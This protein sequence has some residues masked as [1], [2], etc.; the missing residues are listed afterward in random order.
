[1][2]KLT[3]VLLVMLLFGASSPAFAAEYRLNIYTEGNGSVA[4]VPDKTRYAENEVVEL[5]GIAGTDWHFGYWFLGYDAGGNPILSEGNPTTVIMDSNKSIGAYF[6]QNYTL[7]I[8]TTGNG[9]VTREPEYQYY[10]P[11]T[12]VTLHATP[13]L[14]HH[15]GGWYM[16]WDPVTGRPIIIYEATTTIVMNE[17]KTISANF[18]LN[19][20]TIMATA[21]ENGTIDPSGE[22]ML[23][24]NESQTFTVEASPRFHITNVLVDDVP[25]SGTA[26]ATFFQYTFRDVTANH[27]IH[28][29]FEVNTYTIHT[30]S[31]EN[32]SINPSGDVTVEEGNDITFDII[33]DAR[34]HVEDV[35]VDD[36]SVGARNTYTFE[37]VTEDHTI[38]ATFVV[39]TYTIL[40]TAGPNG[41]I[42]P[43]GDIVLEEN[44]SQTFNITP[45]T[46]YHIFDVTVDG[47]SVG[48]TAEH[49]FDDVTFGHTIHA[50]FVINAYT[51]SSSSGL[52]GTISPEG[53]IPVEHGA[54]MRFTITPEARYH[55]ADVLVDSVSVGAVTEHTFY[56]VTSNRSIHATFEVNTY[57]ITATAEGHGTIDPSGDIV[58]EE[59]DERTFTITAEPRYH[60]DNVYVDGAP[61]GAVSSHIISG[62]TSDHQIRAVFL[63]NEFTIVAT[64]GPNGQIDPSGFVPL[65]EGGDQV[66]TITPDRGYHIEDVFVDGTSI[67][68]VPGYTFESV[69]TNHEIHA[70]FGINSYTISAA[71]GPNGRIS[72]SGNIMLTFNSSQAFTFTPDATYHVSNVVVDG[73]SKGAMPG[74]TF[75]NIDT[76]HTITVEFAINVYTISATS[77]P[78]GNISPS[79]NISLE[80]GE[81]QSFTITADLHYHIED[82]LVDSVSA[83]P[84]PGYIFESVTGP[85]TIAATF[86]IDTYIV[87][88]TSGP[89]GAINPAGEV[90]VNHGEDIEFTMIPEEG[91]HVSDVLVDGVSIGPRDSYELTGVEGNRTIHVEFAINEYEIIVTAGANGR[92]EP[93]GTVGT[94]HGDSVAFT[95]TPDEGYHIGD[96]TVDEVS[97]GAPESYTFGYVEDNHE[98][99]AEFEING[100]MITSSAGAH[101]TIDPEG[102]TAIDYG[103]DLTF[104]MKA[105]EGYHVSA[106]VI[107]GLSEEG[108]DTYAFT[109]VES[110][111]TIHAD[112][113]PNQHT[114]TI[115]S[116]DGAV[117]K[118]PDRE[119]YAY[120]DTVELEAVADSEFRFVN[121]SGDASGTENPVTV[122]I[123][124][125]TVVTAH[126]SPDLNAPVITITE[127]PSEDTTVSSSSVTISGFITDEEGILSAEINGSP[128]DLN[129][130]ADGSFAF[131]RR[132]DLVEFDNIITITA[133]DLSNNMTE[134]NIKITLF[135]LAVRIKTTGSTVPL[136]VEFEAEA[137]PFRNIILY[138]WDFDGK[139]VFDQR[140]N[141]ENEAT[142]TYM[143]S[144][145]YF[146]SLRVID[147]S[148]EENSFVISIEVEPDFERSPVITSAKADATVG[149][150]PHSV[151]FTGAAEDP[152]GSIALYEWDFEDDGT[153]DSSSDA[154][155]SVIK[156]YTVAGAHIATLRVTDDE[157]LT[158][159]KEVFIDARWPKPDLPSVTVAIEASPASGPTPLTVDF[160]ATAETIAAG[161]PA[162]VRYEWDFEGD[163]IVDHVSYTPLAT[164]TYANIGKYTTIVKAKAANGVSAKSSV[165][166]LSINNPPDNLKPYKKLKKVEGALPLLVIFEDEVGHIDEVDYYLFDFDGDGMIDVKSRTIE[167]VVHTYKNA[168]LHR[169]KIYVIGVNGW[170][171]EYVLPVQVEKPHSSKM[172]I[173]APKDGQTIS[174]SHIS[175]IAKLSPRIK[176]IIRSMQIQYKTE[177]GEV[178][179]SIGE[180]AGESPYTSSW[181]TTSLPNGPY[182]VRGVVGSTD[183]AQIYSASIRVIIDNSSG[184][185]ELNEEIDSNG[186]HLKKERLIAER[187]N[188]VMLN[189]DTQ[190]YFPDAEM[191]TPDMADAGN[192]VLSLEIVP[193]AEI[194]VPLDGSG[195][196]SLQADSTSY[197][198]I[199]LA[200]EHATFTKD[201]VFTI[202]YQASG[203][204][205][206]TTIKMYYLNETKA[207]WKPIFDS[208][209]YPDGKGGGKVLARAEHFSI[210]G[211]A[212]FLVG[213]G[214]GTA[215]GLA[216]G[217]SELVEDCFIATAAY[218]TA[219]ADEIKVLCHFRDEYLLKRASGKAFV[220]FYYRHSP[221]IAK[222][223]AKRPPLRFIVRTVLKPLVWVL[224]K[225]KS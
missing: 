180:P 62:I 203:G 166:V 128:L 14:Q 45:D 47:A 88:A 83:R 18:L 120:G 66:F 146:A 49:T 192:D 69:T 37:N 214:A 78:N 93:G 33:P 158:A 204:L 73:V 177:L 35:F 137:S 91:Y 115:I 212:G 141:D 116:E 208:L 97:V 28:A 176:K 160:E 130:R 12:E 129:E 162:I 107:D 170:K 152:N 105:E 34:Y 126:F 94:S 131:S 199:T 149:T 175:I 178:W 209:V 19:E 150:I 153:Y 81:S 43:A 135:T 159:T 110:D 123:E 182:D 59:G 109:A 186:R 163:G 2:K 51:I 103:G 48:A 10:V 167:D 67:G 172:F 114:L 1:M 11:G 87:S 216:L 122:L 72:P 138:E 32:G 142:Y 206:E 174:G 27:T 65:N 50:E 144:G 211:L 179:Y 187:S 20:Y 89:H 84:V 102:A 55:V 195:N 58:V 168:R 13:G 29:E 164:H 70:T 96:V 181:D 151:L 124:K 213:A 196:E 157:G 68:A 36:V 79:G 127:G 15:F 173:I 207:E 193:P 111:R 156:T 60:V 56:N 6:F 3:G 74:Y 9:T 113:S 63:V 64:S 24:E 4:R 222:F 52:D 223:I 134:K 101:G 161:G 155:A 26:G 201:V 71:S 86:A 190:V 143:G 17:S 200:D 184:Q 194:G 197:R 183:G 121:W 132:T 198:K 191:I 8:N 99:H 22:V 76:D 41:S 106:L 169:A 148:G 40:A 171:K 44:F 215:G 39:N 42:S 165:S 205:D 139:G 202:P 100:Y 189:D 92:I 140:S 7:T 21:G 53:D 82:V 145:T 30:V 95:I 118:N 85:H 220:R 98:I 23:Y 77:G 38:A 5:T 31:G 117:T 218:G 125:D 54:D 119:T 75:N 46:G 219:L 154:S 16:G 188:K 147:S 25:E 185:A 225:I 217:N 224:E 112:F 221:P 80:H 104:T 133:T 210:F 61:V 57:T 136:E 108:A 90:S